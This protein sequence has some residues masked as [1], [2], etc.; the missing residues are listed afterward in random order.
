MAPRWEWV[1]FERGCLR[2][3][4]S[5]TGVKVVALAVAALE[6]LAGLRERDPAGA[7]IVVYTLARN[8][9]A[10]NESLAQDMNAFGNGCDHLRAAFPGSTILVVHHSGKERH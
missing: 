9:G 8:F 10:S 7:I 1:D 2:F 6:L 5:K 4:T 3:P